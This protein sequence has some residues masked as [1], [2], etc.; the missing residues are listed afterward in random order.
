MNHN[1]E[2]QR[3][4]LLDYLIRYKRITTVTARQELDVMHPAARIQELR[5]RG[6]NIM[7][8]RRMVDTGKGRHDGVAE[9]V[10]L[11]LAGSV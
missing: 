4:K 1:A 7:T 10:L 6:H 9:Y 8:Y 2:S 3:L 5:E 11:K